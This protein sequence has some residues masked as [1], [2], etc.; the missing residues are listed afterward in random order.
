MQVSDF[1]RHRDD[2]DLIVLYEDIKADPVAV[3]KRLLE[4][5]EVPEE[6]IPLALEALLSDSQGG[7]FGK[8]GAKPKVDF[9]F[10][11]PADKLFK[12]CGLPI[13]SRTTSEEFKNLILSGTYEMKTEYDPPRE[14]H[15]RIL[16]GSKPMGFLE[17]MKK[18]RT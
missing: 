14:I 7:T 13:S 10:F 9:E 11:K 15:K 16:A 12:E 4:V 5:C 2:Y 6:H 1:L 18:F 3:C 8:R 17:V